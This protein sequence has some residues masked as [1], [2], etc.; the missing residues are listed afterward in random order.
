VTLNVNLEDVPWAI[1]EVVK[2]RIMANRKKLEEAQEQSLEA[3]LAASAERPQY[4]SI[5]ASTRRRVDPEPGSVYVVRTGDDQIVIWW[6]T[7]SPAIGIAQPS[8]TEVPGEFFDFNNYGDVYETV[9]GLWLVNPIDGGSRNIAWQFT[10]NKF[11]LGTG[12]FTIE[13]YAKIDAMVAAADETRVGGCSARVYYKSFED[14]SDGISLAQQREK[15]PSIPETYFAAAGDFIEGTPEDATR[16][17]REYRV[18]AAGSSVPA[19]QLSHCSLQRINGVLYV[20]FNGTPGSEVFN[21]LGSQVIN[22]G[23]SQMF[24]ELGLSNANEGLVYAGQCRITKRALY[25]T[26]TYTPPADPF[27]DPMP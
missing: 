3:Q 22:Y 18:D 25:G 5:G 24:L 1:L 14:R 17:A 6:P 9:D 12:D 23:Q 16:L 8:Q 7:L 27:Y 21:V 2:A 4:R 15:S 10:F 11:G 19:N 20:H 13:F 26:G